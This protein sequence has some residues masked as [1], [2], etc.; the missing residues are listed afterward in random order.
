MIHKIAKIR[1]FDSTFKQIILV[2]LNFL[3]KFPTILPS[4]PRQTL[5]F[6][7]IPKPLLRLQ[8]SCTCFLSLSISSSASF[9]RVSNWNRILPGLLRLGTDLAL[10]EAQ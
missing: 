1:Y 9:I 3:L 10:A 6:V 5:N 4:Y 2:N 8:L 7:L